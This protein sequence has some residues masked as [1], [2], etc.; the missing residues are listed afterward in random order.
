MPAELAR[1]DE[2]PR[3]G[4]H[5]RVVAQR[6]RDLAPGHLAP[7]AEPVER[8]RAEVGRQP[9][10]V[11]HAP[12]EVGEV[13]QHRADRAHQGSGAPGEGVSGRQV[14][15]PR[16][17]ALVEEERR[18]QPGPPAVGGQV[19]AEVTLGAGLGHADRR[20][21]G[22]GPAVRVKAGVFLGRVVVDARMAVGDD[23]VVAPG[24]GVV[25]DELVGVERDHAAQRRHRP[26]GATAARD[27]EAD[28]GERLHLPRV[29]GDHAAAHAARIHTGAAHAAVAIAAPAHAALYIICRNQPVALPNPGQGRPA[30]PGAMVVRMQR[31]LVTTTPD[32]V[33][34][35]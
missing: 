12:V 31:A 19:A 15:Q 7:R 10:R 13:R 1:V 28:L 6:G 8:H 29:H 9:H 30:R 33:P 16:V 3:A 11:D 27:L 20:A 2:L 18:G 14:Q 32:T 22:H 35:R 4:G 34:A 25:G 21:G 24:G 5:R 23:A 26:V 17:A